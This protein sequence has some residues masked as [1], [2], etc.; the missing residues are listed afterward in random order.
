[1]KLRTKLEH[2]L[3]VV[4]SVLLF[5]VWMWGCGQAGRCRIPINKPFRA[6]IQHPFIGDY[7]YISSLVYSPL[8]PYLHVELVVILTETI[9]RGRFHFYVEVESSK[10]TAI[11][12]YLGVRCGGASFKVML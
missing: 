9:L 3:S 7:L 8:Q 6:C 10:S 12:F 2:G 1:M 5:T 11:S 4:A